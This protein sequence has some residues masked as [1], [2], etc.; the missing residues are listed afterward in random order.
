MWWLSLCRCAD[1]AQHWL[2]AQEE[3]LNDLYIVARITDDAAS[4]IRSRGDWPEALSTY[5]ELLRIGQANGHAARY[6]D[7]SELWPI[8]IDLVGQRATLDAGTLAE[9]VQVSIDDAQALLAR[10]KAEIARLGY[11]YPWSVAG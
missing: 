7:P 3:R 5:E 4:D 9:L 1:C 10:A 11:P 2:V 8:A 6:G